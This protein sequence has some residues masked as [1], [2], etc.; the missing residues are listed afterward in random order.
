[1]KKQDKN[2]FKNKLEELKV[3]KEQIY[4]QM[5]EQASDPDTI[6]HYEQQAKE[7]G[8]VDIEVFDENYQTP[9]KWKW[10]LDQ[11]KN[12]NFTRIEEIFIKKFSKTKGYTSITNQKQY[13]EYSDRVMELALKKQT[14]KVED[15]MELLELLIANWE[16]KIYQMKAK[17][18]ITLLKDLMEI[19]QIK[20][21]D[22]VKILGIPK[23]DVSQ[24]LSYKIGL[25]KDT[26]RKLSEHFKL[27]Q[28]AFDR[29]YKLV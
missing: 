29:P 4:A 3:N 13:Q 28:E 25:S 20:S 8:D 9:E 24:I 5:K 14:K 22:L 7:L 23:S 27:S 10:L 26:I 2:L 17:D 11:K 1:M 12:N 16:T 6:A 21:V 19:H 18:P 15:E